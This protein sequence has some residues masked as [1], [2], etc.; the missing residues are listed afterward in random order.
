MTL[1]ALADNGRPGHGPNWVSML[2]SSIDLAIA[3]GQHSM[4]GTPY[5]NCNHSLWHLTL[6]DGRQVKLSE[7][8][9]FAALAAKYE[10][11]L[12]MVSGDDKLCDEVTEKIPNCVAAA[13]KQSLGIQSACS[14]TPAAA[15]DLIREKVL[16]GVAQKNSV[17]PLTYKRPFKLNVSDRTQP[18]IQRLIKTCSM[19]NSASQG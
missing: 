3:I 12:V 4:A 2:D 16:E 8:T 1:N 15:Q 14:L 10:V 11:P 17:S 7:T 9:M 6:G 19:P 13:V 5:G 18:R